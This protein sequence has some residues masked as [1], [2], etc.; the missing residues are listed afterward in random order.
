[1]E[2]FELSFGIVMPMALTIFAGYLLAQRKI[3][4][5][6]GFDAMNVLAFKLLLPLSLF[7]N[8]YNGGGLEQMNAR[9]ILWAFVFQILVL[10]ILFLAVPRLIPENPKR[11]SVIQACFRSN[12]ITFGLVIAGTFCTADELTVVSVL[13][14][15]M[16]PFYNIGGVCI[17]EYYRGGTLK[18]RKLLVQVMKNPFVISCLLA[19]FLVYFHIRLPLCVTS[20]VKSIGGCASPISFLALGGALDIRA[21]GKYRKDIAVGVLF[22]LVVQPFIVIGLAI[23]LGFRGIELLA[24]VVMM[25][26]PTAV[27]TY[28]M[29]QNMDAD[30]EL[31]GYLVVFQSLVSLLTIFG[32]IWL[33]NGIGLLS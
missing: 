24:I 33:L 1:M 2:S 4:S 12:F 32:W 8:I 19:L 3:I 17:L 30:G 26:S 6:Q 13:A 25:I 15:V 27:A 10:V 14:G 7:N 11:A 5:Q 23:L 16:I 9:V 18:P 31:A 21:A 22:R 29:A 20:A 28:S